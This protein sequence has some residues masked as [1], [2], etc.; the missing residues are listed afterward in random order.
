MEGQPQY[1]ATQDDGGEYGRLVLVSTIFRLLEEPMEDQ[2]QQYLPMYR[3]LEDQSQYLPISRELE[4]SMEGQSQYLDICIQCVGRDS[5]RL[6]LSTYLGCR[7]SKQRTIPSIYQ[8]SGCWRRVG[9]LVLVFTFIPGTG[10]ESRGLVLGFPYTQGAGGEYGG[11]VPVFTYIQGSGGE[12]RELVLL[13]T[14]IRT[15]TR[16]RSSVLTVLNF[17]FIHV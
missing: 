9:G 14:Y 6:M 17:T 1:L 5:G 8:Y 2:S 15:V 12:S 3:V 16:Y 10:V 11:L 13:F 4:E 7:R